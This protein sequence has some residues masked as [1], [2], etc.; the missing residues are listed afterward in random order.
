MKLLMSAY[1]KAIGITLLVYSLL[2]FVVLPK[3]VIN[4]AKTIG[5]EVLGSPVEI[6]EMSFN[7]F[8]FEITLTDVKI[9]TLESHQNQAPTRL[10]LK[11]LYLNFEPHALFKKEIK[12]KAL[13]LEQVK[14]VFALLA[15]DKTNWEIASADPAEPKKVQSKQSPWTLYFENLSIQN[16]EVNFLD[17]TLREPLDLKM[18]PLNLGLQNF[19][20]SIG[21]ETSLKKLQFAL[22][23]EGLL[24][25]TGKFSTKPIQAEL[26][27]KSRDLPLGFLSSFLLEHSYLEIKEGLADLDNKLTYKG[28][29]ILVTGASHI[30]N[31]NLQ[32]QQSKKSALSFKNL[33]ILN[34]TFQT[35]PLIFNAEKML[36][37]D[38][39]ITLI[40]KKD[41]K[42]NVSEFKRLT[43]SNQSVSKTLRRDTEPS[44]IEN[45]E[46]TNSKKQEAS[47]VAPN[48]NIK[49][50]QIVNGRLDFN[51][52]QIQP[53]FSALV[54]KLNGVISP[55]KS[56]V[57]KTNVNLNGGVEAFGKFLAKGY[58]YTGSK[59]PLLNLNV[60]F[61]NIEMTTFTPYSGEFAGYEINKGKLFL[62]LNY[63]LDRNLIKGTNDV[64]LDQFTLGKAVE[65]ENSPNLPL[66]LALALMRDRDGQIKFNL[67]VEGDVKN[68][69]FSFSNLVWTALKNMLV[70]I[71][72]APFD[73]I[74]GLVGGEDLAFVDFAVGKTEISAEQKEKI[75]KLASVL[76]DK[77]ELKLEIKGQYSTADSEILKFKSEAEYKKWT[78]L[79][80]ESILKVLT[81]L[82]ISAE[83]VFILA[84]QKVETNEP[85]VKTVLSF[86]LD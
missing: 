33:Q 34:Y 11:K 65:S 12:L 1:V 6:S 81:E 75:K 85:V 48:W 14:F 51:D 31:L 83:R 29:Q 28:G 74:K 13:N 80:A 3:M 62:N 5:S 53:N 20:T 54:S 68:P 56:G 45:S 4:K 35:K 84:S 40:L 23:N 38:P 66:K 39:R 61:S 42:L 17:Y 52:Q 79:R 9:N 72:A 2:G 76:I 26:Q 70:N 27:I 47:T 49:E 32:H 25:L 58:V 18:G 50:F 59:Q 15:H 36:L 78:S 43:P 67:P 63:S 86:K 77:P 55:I 82:Q 73:F 69:K 8:S 16:S 24:E 46:S 22:A 10:M 41:G 30:K 44:K 37:T 60:N 7:P 64:R 19:S 57:Q 71:V 21:A